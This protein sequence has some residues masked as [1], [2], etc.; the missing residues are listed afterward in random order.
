MR[1]QSAIFRHLST[2][3]TTKY[4]GPWTGP[5]VR[6]Q[7]FEFFR[8]KNHVLVPSSSTVPFEDPTLLFSNSGMNQVCRDELLWRRRLLSGSMLSSNL[9]SLALLTLTQI[10]RS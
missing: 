6:Q 3:S 1:T 7:F 5:R 4:T 2:M 9:S 8:S 10:S